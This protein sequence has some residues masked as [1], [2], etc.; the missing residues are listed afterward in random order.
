MALRAVTSLLLLL[1]LAAPARAG[2]GSAGHPAGRLTLCDV[3]AHAATFQGD[4]R[5][6]R[7]VTLLQMR[8][9]LQVRDG[10]HP[11][12]SHVEAPTFDSWL[13]SAAGKSRYV[14]DKSVANMPVG[15]TYRAVVRFRWRGADGTILSHAKRTTRA[16][17][18]PDDRPDLRATSVRVRPGSSPDARRYV[19]RVVNEGR[20]DAD[21]FAVG[22]AVDGV[23]LGDRFASSLAAGADETVAFEGPAC[24]SG[25][26]L[27][28]TVDASGLVDEADEADD[29]LTV[30]C[31]SNRR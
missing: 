6:F 11:R 14:Y 13:S 8:F 18:Q 20:G 7:R 24:T 30:P 4:M 5:R 15:A 9:T 17:R 2:A 23:S 19:A 21:A 16:C 3:A 22:L 10:S 1:V 27:T 29:A 31:P 25:S 12:W 28:A 26:R